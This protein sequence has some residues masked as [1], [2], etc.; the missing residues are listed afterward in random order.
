METR[1]GIIRGFSKSCFV[2]C[3]HIQPGRPIFFIDANYKGNKLICD[4]EKKT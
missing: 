3:S 1:K 2:C 4:M